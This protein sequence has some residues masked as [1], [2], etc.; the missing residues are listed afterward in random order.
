MIS[1]YVCES[2]VSSRSLQIASKAR[3]GYGNRRIATGAAVDGAL[4][5]ELATVI[6]F[7]A[8]I[9]GS[10]SVVTVAIR[11][12]QRPPINLACPPGDHERVEAVLRRNSGSLTH[13][14]A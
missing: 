6:V 14:R 8:G 9:V 4:A 5:C 7:N 13:S 11:V 3:Y 12:V 10:L 2:G 1:A